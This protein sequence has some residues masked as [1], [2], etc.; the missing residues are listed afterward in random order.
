ML[1]GS[2]SSGWIMWKSRSSATGGAMAPTMYIESKALA[3]LTNVAYLPRIGSSRPAQHISSGRH[4]C[5]RYLIQPVLRRW[6]V[7]GCGGW[8][9]IVQ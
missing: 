8:Y 3:A 7:N 4:E 5:S 9:V 2:G 6:V 1:G